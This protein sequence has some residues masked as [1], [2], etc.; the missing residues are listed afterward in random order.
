MFT[1]NQLRLQSF[2]TT[3]DGTNDEV[4]CTITENDDGTRESLALKN[5]FNFF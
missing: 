5:F 1:T 3:E 4:C 2:R